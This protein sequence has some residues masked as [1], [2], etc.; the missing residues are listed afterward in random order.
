VDYQKKLKRWKD[1]LG[2]RTGRIN[3]VKMAV[4]PKIAYRFSTITTETLTTFFT[5]YIYKTNKQ[6]K[7]LK[8]IKFTDAEKTSISRQG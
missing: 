2:S 8:F 6:T 4:F 3:F 7:N 1:L 5:R